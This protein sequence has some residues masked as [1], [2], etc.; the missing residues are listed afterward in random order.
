MTQGKKSRMMSRDTDRFC[1]HVKNNAKDVF[2]IE[3]ED[4]VWLTRGCGEEERREMGEVGRSWVQRF[5]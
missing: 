2:V 4:R 1:L 3:V 5:K